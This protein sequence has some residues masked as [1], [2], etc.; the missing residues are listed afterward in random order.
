MVEGGP[1]P[2]LATA[3]AAVFHRYAA[4]ADAGDFPSLV[5]LHQAPCLRLHGDGR[6]EC[7]DTGEAVR[8]YFE[9]LA[10]RYRERGHARGRWRDLE[11]AP[12]GTAAAQASLTWEML[13]ADGA[14]YRRFRRTY[15]LNR[16]AA[17]AWRIL[18]VVA[19]R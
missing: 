13:G 1:D 9:A 19:H 4:A 6:A 11:V 10:A 7:L 2:A 16:D 15:V 18:L 5:A 17:G 14:V 3:L 12:I 8:A